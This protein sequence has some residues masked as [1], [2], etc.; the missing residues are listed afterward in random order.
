MPLADCLWVLFTDSCQVCIAKRYI[1]NIIRTRKQHILLSDSPTH[2]GGSG[3]SKFV[4]CGD[5]VFVAPG[6]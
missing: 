2:P 6:M 4:C 3:W 1:S 5:V